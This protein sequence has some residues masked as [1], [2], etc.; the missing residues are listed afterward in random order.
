MDSFKIPLGHAQAVTNAQFQLLRLE[1]EPILC[2]R[3]QLFMALG[4]PQSGAGAQKSLGA[5]LTPSWPEHISALPG[6][7]A[8]N[9]TEPKC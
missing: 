5:E 8:Q 1:V 3:N 2:T 7:M 4:A 6:V 9:R